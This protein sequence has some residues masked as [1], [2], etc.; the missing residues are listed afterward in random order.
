MSHH[1]P[2]RTAWWKPTA[3]T[4]TIIILA[5]A[6]C[7]ALAAGCIRA[8]GSVRDGLIRDAQI[9]LMLPILALVLWLEWNYAA[10]IWMEKMPDVQN[11][12]HRNMIVKVLDIVM[13]RDQL[14]S[15]RLCGYI[16]ALLLLPFVIATTLWAILIFLANWR[17]TDYA[18]PLDWLICR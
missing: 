11:A 17:A 12:K 18:M 3:G 6:I 14:W 8:C 16:L 10:P 2:V 13:G 9:P 15:T 7:S 4:A 5:T 1:E